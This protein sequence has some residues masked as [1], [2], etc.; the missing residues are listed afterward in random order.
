VGDPSRQLS[1]SIAA[2]DA[3][4]AAH[5]QQASELYAQ[6][7]RATAAVLAD[8]DA[9]MAEAK[10]ETV[11]SKLKVDRKQVT[12]YADFPLDK[13]IRQVVLMLDQ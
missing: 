10:D 7:Q 1:E 3:A 5:G 6:G 9:R 8:F 4:I 12:K 13:Y 2:L 11:V